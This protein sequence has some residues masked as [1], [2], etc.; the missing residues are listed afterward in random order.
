MSSG[1]VWGPAVEILGSGALLAQSK[2]ILKMVA[3]E[4]SDLVCKWRPSNVS[5][6]L[7]GF[8]APARWQMGDR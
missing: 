3:L 7:S 6:F 8:I 4:I 1:M 5:L 2:Y